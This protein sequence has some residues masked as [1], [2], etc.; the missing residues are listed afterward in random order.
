MVPLV[1]QIILKEIKMKKHLFLLEHSE[2]IFFAYFSLGRKGSG[3]AMIQYMIW[4]SRE[5]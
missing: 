5:D 2:I 3:S 1:E 4:C